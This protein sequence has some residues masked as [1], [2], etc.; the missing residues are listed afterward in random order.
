MSAPSSSQ[1]IRLPGFTLVELL[2]VIGIIALLISILLPSLNSARRAAAT[3]KCKSNLRQVGLALTMYAQQYQ[4]RFPAIALN[5]QAVTVK[6]P[7]VAGGIYSS[8]G[9]INSVVY[10]FERLQIDGFMTGGLDPAK[11]PMICPSQVQPYAPPLNP[12]PNPAMPNLFNSSY[13]MNEF[14]SIYDPT[15]N[16]SPGPW[17]IDMAY[18]VSSHGYRKVDWPK[19]LN[20]PHSAE[21]IVAADNYSDLLLE[22]YDPNTIPNNDSSYDVVNL[23]DQYDWHRHAS[24][25]AKYGFCN[26]LYLDGHVATCNQGPTSTQSGIDDLNNVS[27]ICGLDYHLSTAVIAKAVR[28]TQPY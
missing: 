18:L 28:E 16:K 9:D 24:H 3:V 7:N 21:T 20:A 14:L 23:P 12:P 13:G 6:I 11:S 4:Q 19:V 2:V 26:V 15:G 22:P 17:P 25:T 8:T 5:Y 1:R 10:W 27:D